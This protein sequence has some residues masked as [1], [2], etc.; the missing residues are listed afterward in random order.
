MSGYL[1][2]LQDSVVE[3]LLKKVTALKL[4]QITPDEAYGG[5]PFRLP[6]E[7]PAAF[8]S[9]TK[10]ELAN[11]DGT[12]RLIFDTFWTVLVLSGRGRESQRLNECRELAI[13]VSWAIENEHFGQE[14]VEP[15]RVQ[16]IALASLDPE[17]AKGGT[18][19]EVNFS[20]V[21]YLDKE[22]KEKDEEEA[23]RLLL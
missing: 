12:R 4:C 11:R 16:D 9:I 5:G 10:A 20:Q 19:W 15:A 3:T 21:V 2:E 18:I 14:N 8:V 7:R 1:D 17:L 6:G 13:E 22:Q 23:L